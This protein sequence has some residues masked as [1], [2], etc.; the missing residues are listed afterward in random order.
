MLGV[1]SM[2]LHPLRARRASVHG[3]LEKLEDVARAH[4]LP[5]MRGVGGEVEVGGEGDGRGD[6]G[7]GVGLLGSKVWCGG[8]GGEGGAERGGRGGVAGGLKECVM[9]MEFPR[10]V[11]FDLC[12]HAVLCANCHRQLVQAEEEPVCP[13]CGGPAIAGSEPSDDVARQATFVCAREMRQA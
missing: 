2:L 6:D 10:Q 8:R 9:C 11:R 5:C 4:A 13:V 12:G 7:D 1:A 3:C